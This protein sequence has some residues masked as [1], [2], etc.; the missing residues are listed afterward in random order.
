MHW[1]IMHWS[2]RVI[3][4]LAKRVDWQGRKE[5]NRVDA[6]SG[7]RKTPQGE[8]YGGEGRLANFSAVAGE[9]RKRHEEHEE[10]AKEEVAQG[11][12]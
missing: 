4:N 1:G 10:S 7:Q 12:E 11:A 2:A 3:G 8:P 9:G 5:G 6:G